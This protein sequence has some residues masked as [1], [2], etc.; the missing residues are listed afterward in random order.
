MSNNDFN[1]N[2]DEYKEVPTDEQD[3]P[4]P[5]NDGVEPNPE[6]PEQDAAE[7]ES[8]APA[9]TYT[10]EQKPVN[11]TE[12]RAACEVADV[13]AELKDSLAIFRESFKTV[14]EVMRLNEEL[15]E[16]LNERETALQKQLINRGKE[17]TDE[18]G[19]LWI[20]VLFDA[21]AS[22]R[23]DNIGLNTL[24]REGS[25]WRQGL[26][27]EGKDLRPGRPKQKLTNGHNKDEILSYVANKSGTGA[28]FDFP[29][30]HSGLWIRMKSPSL[31]AL[32]SLQHELNQV[33]ISLGSDTK[34]MAFSNTSQVLTSIATDFA[35][36]YAVDA[37]CN[38]RTPSDLKE[39]IVTLDIPSLLLAC[40][41]TLFPRGY[42]YMAPCVADMDKCQFVV[43]EKLNL[44][45]LQRVDVN[46]L[47]RDQRQ[48]M[49][50]RF[51]VKYTDEQLDAY[52]KQHQHG[53]ERVVWFDDIG[54][55]LS[56]PT[57]Q[58]HEEAG[59]AWIDGII[60]MTQG[61]FNEPPHG[62]NR[63]RYI[64][65]LGQTTTARQY[66]HWVS[67]VLDRDDDGEINEISSD[68]EVIAAT[69]DQV[70]SAN[71]FAELFFKQVTEYIEDSM[72]SMVAIR[73]YNCPKCNTPVA[74][75]FHERFE[76][77]VPLD[78]LTTFFTLASRKLNQ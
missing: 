75:K 62:A 3:F 40:A 71:E 9:P 21:F 60:E 24:S 6:A 46:A 67:G 4:L 51:S 78:M 50:T 58:Q 76:H 38:F 35:L 34:G 56:V 57:L 30:Y 14:T 22:A 59:K 72:I 13:A 19:N 52:R 66:A 33:R 61:A 53:G 15:L 42:N 54:L 23:L 37:N 45:H 16:Q 43:K 69:L 49:A 28:T 65:Q 12:A 17:L 18:D 64:D 70:L 27:H 41:A 25:D 68:T 26:E 47:T 1:E 63:N 2:Q 48:H 10:P 32:A 36:S 29:M 55:K 77:L 39:R 8:E 74:E 73:S 44:Q 11:F 5:G 20:R 7:N 31:S